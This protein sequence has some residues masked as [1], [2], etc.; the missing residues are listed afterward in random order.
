VSGCPSDEIEPRLLWTL[1]LW[2]TRDHTLTKRDIAR[3]IGEL[4][5]IV[6]D[7]SNEETDALFAIARVAGQRLLGT[8]TKAV[9]EIAE[10]GDHLRHYASQEVSLSVMQSLLTRLRQDLPQFIGEEWTREFTGEFDDMPTFTIGLIVGK[11]VVVPLAKA[12]FIKV[13][14]VPV[15]PRKPTPPELGP[16]KPPRGSE[17]WD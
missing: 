5:G 17:W 1:G 4:A 3:R 10:V 2:D 11:A 7:L 16:P 8:G 9:W 6:S 13:W 14:P 12:G 15:Q